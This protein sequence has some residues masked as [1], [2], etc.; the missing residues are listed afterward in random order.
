MN[1]NENKSHTTQYLKTKCSTWLKYK[2]CA[3]NIPIL[4]L[5]EEKIRAW[6]DL[7]CIIPNCCSLFIFFLSPHLAQ[8]CSSGWPRL[9]RASWWSCQTLPFTTTAWRN[10]RSS[11]SHAGRA[12]NLPWPSSPG[13]WNILP[14]GETDNRATYYRGTHIFALLAAACVHELHIYTFCAYILLFASASTAVSQGN[15]KQWKTCLMQKWKLGIFH[16]LR[17]YNS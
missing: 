6:A 15:G 8:F 17:N 4:C 1:L 11:P 10:A 12:A 14:T 7:K 13:G 9:C 3:W 16:L 5:T 2:L